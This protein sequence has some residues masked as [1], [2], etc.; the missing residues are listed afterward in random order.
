MGPVV[1]AELVAAM[2]PAFIA[3]LSVSLSG[4]LFSIFFGSAPSNT[5]SDENTAGLPATGDSASAH[6]KR[7]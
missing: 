3:T 7:D 4:D 2:G 1:L 5:A 6:V